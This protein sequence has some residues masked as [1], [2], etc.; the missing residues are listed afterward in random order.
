MPDRTEHVS[1]QLIRNIQD[2]AFGDPEAAISVTQLTGGSIN[3]TFQVELR[4]RS[5]VII[6]IAPSEAAAAAGPSWLTPWGLRREQAV[7]A[8]AAPALGSL[9]PRTIAADFNHTLVDRDWVIQE[10][11]PGVPVS[12]LDATLPTDKRTALWI[13]IGQLT[14]HLHAT[15]GERFGAPVA[16]P[17]FDR[18]S[19][20]LRNDAD[21][22]LHDAER[23]ELPNHAFRRLRDRIDD[24]GDIF[25]D[26]PGPRLVHSDLTSSHVFVQPVG[27]AE[28]HYHVSGIIDLEYGRFADPRSEG[29]ISS[30]QCGNAP[31]EVKEAFFAGYGRHFDTP[32][33]RLRLR[34]YAA[35]ALSWSATLLA[36][37]DHRESLP[38]V[39]EQLEEA[40]ARSE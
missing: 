35:F 33:D 16:G 22:L 26:N 17:R 24:L 12:M 11:V 39:I 27:D 7:I 25:D 3:A 32:E 2:I 18:L 19:D 30:F 29:V 28:D 5:S 34:I 21:G 38:G 31:M 14:R 10:R 36:F 37:H 23:F 1:G 20:L 40:L 9:L 6:R 8:L 13:E 4:D 15:T